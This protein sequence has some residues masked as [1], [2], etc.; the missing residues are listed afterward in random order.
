VCAIS[1]ALVASVAT[2][3]V[4]LV[5]VSFFGLVFAGE[6]SFA[7]SGLARQIGASVEIEATA[8]MELVAVSVSELASLC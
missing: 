1:V 8:A 6:D 2:V 4:D 7:F 5:V 3:V